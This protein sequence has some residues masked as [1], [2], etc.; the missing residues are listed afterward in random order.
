MKK[1]YLITIILL[2][3][4]LQ[5]FAQLQSVSFYTDYSSALSTR[6]QVTSGDAV[7]GG[8]KIKF[9]VLDKFAISINGGY[10]LYSLR[11]PD[12]L[13]NWGWIFWTDRYYNKVVSDL[14]ADQNLS[15]DI[16]AIQKMDLIPLFVSFSYD[17]LPLEKLEITPSFGGGFYLFTRRMYAVENWDKYFPDE[18]YIFSYSYRNFAPTKTGNPFFINGGVNIQYKLFE[19][20]NIFSNAQ[21]N[22]VL[23]TDGSLGYD[24]FPLNSEISIALGISIF[25]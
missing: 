3:S 8:V 12:V 16:S 1:I 18:D 2:L 19:S 10:K 9:K 15:V 5:L 4:S 24:A 21:Y 17:F 13:N 6:L 22:Y 23:R 14:N 20:L 7:G 11:E 25:Y